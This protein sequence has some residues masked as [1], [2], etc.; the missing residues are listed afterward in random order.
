M[1]LDELDIKLTQ[2]Q[3]DIENLKTYDSLIKDI[4]KKYMNKFKEN[5]KELKLMT[6]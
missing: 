6:N 1:D 2:A 4:D 5:T 3:H